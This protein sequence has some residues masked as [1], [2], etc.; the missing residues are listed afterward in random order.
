[1]NSTE[2]PQEPLR[3]R[4]WELVDRHGDD[5]MEEGKK[6]LRRA[7]RTVTVVGI[8]VAAVAIAIVVVI[9]YAVLR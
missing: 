9:V 5:Y 8:V 6:L 7:R 4:M 1:M 3:D 2:E